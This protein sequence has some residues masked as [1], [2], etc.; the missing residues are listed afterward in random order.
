MLRY[1]VDRPGQLVTKAT[2]LDAVWAGVS[3]SDSMPAICVAE[4]AGPRRRREDSAVYRDRAS[5]RLSL[6]RQ[7]TG[8]APEETTRKPPASR[9]VPNR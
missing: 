5:P 7:V 9:E 1:L 8:A 2:L 6:Y 3:V 4:L